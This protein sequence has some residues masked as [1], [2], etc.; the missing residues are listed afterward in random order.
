M[1]LMK[2]STGAKLVDFWSDEMVA[3]CSCHLRLLVVARIRPEV[4]FES[5]DE[6]IEAS[7]G[8]GWCMS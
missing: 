5:F 1:T 8:S 6:L 4:K 2:T 3:E 7:P